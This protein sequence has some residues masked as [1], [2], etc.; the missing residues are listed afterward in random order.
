MRPLTDT[1]P[2]PMIPLAGRPMIDHAIDILRDAGIE[3]IVAN[4]HY[5][6]DEIAPHL[7]DRRV[8]ISHE[9]DILDTGGGLRAALPLLGDGPVVTLN[10][11]AAWSGANPVQELM[12]AWRSDMTAL[13]L[14]QPL[15]SALE[16]RGQ[17]DFDMAPDGTLTRGDALV[18]T[19][20]Q[21]IRTDQ[22]ADVPGKAFS[23]NAYW[24]RLTLHGTL[25]KGGW[26]DIGHP[27]GLTRAEALLADA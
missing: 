15:K 17:G 26:C 22:L 7:R 14:M 3:R 25:H 23:L 6:H 12:A 11:D 1:L 16:R 2:K 10:P 18:Y 13:L 19:G 27:A 24:D 9:P 20:A 5:L 4:T 21:I 8:T